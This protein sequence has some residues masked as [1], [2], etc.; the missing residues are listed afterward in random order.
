MIVHDRYSLR[1][2]N[3][4][5]FDVCAEHYAGVA[6]EDELQEAVEYAAHRRWPVFVLGGGSNIVLTRNVPGL[7]IR[8]TSATLT[9]D[10]EKLTA[11]AGVAWDNLVRQS[12]D[13]GL[14]GLENLSLIPGDTGA[15]PMQNIGAY[16][17]ELADRLLQLRV[18]H[19][20]SREWRIHDRDDC[21]FG[22]R[23]SLFK[24]ER[25]KHVITSITLGLGSSCALV[26]DYTSLARE[27]EQQE[28]EHP[29]AGDIAAA[30]V[31]IRRSKLPDPTRIGNA[32]SFF[33]NPL[34]DADRFASLERLTP[35]LI[36]H[37]DGMG[38]V[39][40]AA[41]QLIEACGFK[42]VSRGAV[43]VHTEQALVLVHHGRGKGAELLA[44]AGEITDAVRERYG[45]DLIIEPVV[46]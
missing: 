16:G 3:T 14:N 4:L 38:R 31:R 6:S 45:V 10:G 2:S 32:G 28:I 46:L 17:V 21:R 9:R 33:K 7:V 24:Q 12:L 44:L 35:G 40:L 29:Q 18:F 26:A 8:Q 27:L 5:G 42:G 34:V 1:T 43:G 37:P 19:L 41:A 25:G 36:G 20:P 15:A 22:Y 30:V 11:S 23:D 39:K 13:M